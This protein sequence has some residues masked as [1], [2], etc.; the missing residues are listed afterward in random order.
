MS[1]LT[2]P[3]QITAEPTDRIG[4]RVLLLDAAERLFV[5][6]LYCWLVG[7]MVPGVMAGSRIGD[8]LLLLG[9]GIVVVF[10]MIRRR[11]AEIS[12]SPLE[13]LLALGGTCL[14]LL[15]VA[16]DTEPWMPTAAVSAMLIGLSVQFHAKLTLGRSIG[17]VPAHR[18]L[19]TSG[20]YR[21]VRHPM[22]GGYLLTQ[23]GFLALNPVWWNVS[24]YA[25]CHLLQVLRILAE[26]RFLSRDPAYRDYQS[27]V[28]YRILPG[29]F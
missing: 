8:M 28:A 14:P 22:Y 23:I 4:H 17:M 20:L 5:L 19:K 7:R 10:F 18:G 26:E 2:F 6:G 25:M 21:F 29:I 27:R 9:E 24:V 13:W 15:V 12:R 11:T 1:I 16:G 3:R